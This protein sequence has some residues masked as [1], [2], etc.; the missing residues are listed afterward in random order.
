MKT[1]SED[2]SFLISINN[3]VAIIKEREELLFIIFQ[4][5]YE[6]YGIEIGGGALFDKTK[7][8][9]GLLIVKIEE[10][11]RINDSLIWQQT[12]SV[13]SIP[14]NLS[15]SEPGITLL[16]TK[17]FYL[18]K[19]RNERQLLLEDVL[20]EMHIN[21]LS[22]ISVRTGGELIGFLIL[23]L[24]KTNLSDKDEDY[25]LKLANL[26]G[27]VIKNVNSYDEVKRR[28]KEK[29][30]QLGLLT[31]LVTIRDKEELFKKLADETDKIIPCNYIAFH[32][33]YKSMDLSGTISLIKD[34][35]DL[36]KIITL[37][38]SISLFL[39][40]MKTKV[41]GKNGQNYLEASGEEFNKL[42][43]Q[44]SHL[45]QLKEKDS[46]NSLLVLQY[47]F[48]NLGGL[49]LVLGRRFPY[50]EMKKETTMELLFA[51]NRNTFFGLNEIDLAMNLL[52]YLGLI[53]SNYYAFEEI[54]I[55]TKNL[56]QEKNYLLDEINLTNNIQ[57][58]IGD[59]QPINYA[60]NKVKQVA[61]LDA[62]V[63]ILGETGTGKELIAKAIH[64]LS[65]RK[66]NVF[67]TVNCAALPVQLIE[68]ELFGHEKG[69]FTGAL[70][71]RIGKF[72]VANGGTIFLDEI[73]ELPLEIQAK[74]LR[75]LQ[76]KEFE[77]LG[78][79]ST[80]YS[81]VRIVAATN[82]DLEKE[83]KQ[84]KFR[85][86]LFFRLN[87]FPIVVPPLR[88]RKEDIPLLVKYFIDKYS[89][90]VGKELKSIKKSDLDMLLNYSWPGNIRE[91]EHIIERAIIVSEGPNFNLEKLFGGSVQQTEPDYKTFKSLLENEKEHIINALKIS[92][93]KI[94]GENSA[95][96]LLGINGKTLGS[97]MRK[98]KIKREFIITT[99]KN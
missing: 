95:A 46:I 53:L 33:E 52:P 50:S 87:V 9:L 78:G 38:R 20:K 96:Q 68:S 40:A 35:K 1:A 23:A 97:K 98:L 74:L 54:K 17:Y 6:F 31:D 81:D 11:K 4:K 90:K 62:T 21:N 19:P 94:T 45:K 15:I 73:G 27:S 66:Q 86:D 44:F 91:L 85:S 16:D 25:L 8:N 69:S 76:E 79:K 18:L 61:P 5:L 41:G 88:K 55:L 56:E 12:F 63:L 36:F 34:E 84:G 75:V 65:N 43:E 60:L 28:E 37:T 67:I 48:G 93:G 24:E 83:V 57:E 3:D 64:N 72:E 71:K 26:I 42:C 82:R 10:G 51:K 49:T 29:E 7:E 58:I 92:N 32:S 30:I 80:V 39:L 14:F 70:E 99:D 59:S 2:L 13:N 89:K 47:A 77:R 22:L